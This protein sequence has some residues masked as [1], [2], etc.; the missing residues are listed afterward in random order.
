MLRLARP[1][2]ILPTVGHTQAWM[3]AKISTGEWCHQGYTTPAKQL[4]LGEERT[5]KTINVYHISS[6][7]STRWWEMLLHRFMCTVLEHAAEGNKTETSVPSSTPQEQW[8]ISWCSMKQWCQESILHIFI[9]GHYCLFDLE[10]ISP[11]ALAGDRTVPPPARAIFEEWLHGSD[12]DRT[13]RLQHHIPI[14]HFTAI[15]CF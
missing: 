5:I 10:F 13:P 7:N 11:P 12:R 14:I 6:T 15:T 9:T 8:N 2:S 1:S 4:G 3:W